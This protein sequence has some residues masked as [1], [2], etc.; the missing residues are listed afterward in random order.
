MIHF[1]QLLAGFTATVCVVLLVRLCLGDARQRRF[2]N[3]VRS[4][5]WKLRHGARQVWRAPAARRTAA[6]EA[7]SAIERA[8]NG[9][10]PVE[11]NDGD[12][13]GNVYTPKSFRKPRKPH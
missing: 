10:A 13:Q 2:D 8:R 4:M 1:E 6:S 3:A 12:W 9:R 5:G 11:P 7:R